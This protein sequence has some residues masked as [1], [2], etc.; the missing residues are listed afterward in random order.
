MESVGIIICVKNNCTCAH[1]LEVNATKRS[2]IKGLIW[3]PKRKNIRSFILIK[4][5]NPLY[6]KPMIINHVKPGCQSHKY[7]IE[8]KK[9]ISTINPWSSFLYTRDVSHTQLSLT[10]PILSVHQ[11]L[12]HRATARS[13]P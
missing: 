5:C 8:T 11:L 4:F 2:A 10:C 13:R 7:L 3:A 6:N 9:P 12:D 1:P